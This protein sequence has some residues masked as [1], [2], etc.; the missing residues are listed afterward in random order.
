MHRCCCGSFIG[1]K[2]SEKKGVL[3]HPK[4]SPFAPEK[5]SLFGAG[6]IPTAN[7]DYVKAYGQ[8]LART[9]KVRKIV[10]IDKY[11]Q[12]DRQPPKGLRKPRHDAGQACGGAVFKN[13]S[14]V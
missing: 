4:R 6:H 13:A 14:D 8:P 7:S 11:D 5:E 9:N 10:V 1:L 2:S 3:L 12:L